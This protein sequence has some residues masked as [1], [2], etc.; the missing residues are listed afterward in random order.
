MSSTYIGVASRN[1]HFL[2][3]K[4][5]VSKTR[6]TR[7]RSRQAIEDHKL[8]HRIENASSIKEKTHGMEPHLF[9]LLPSKAYKSTSKLLLHL[10]NTPLIGSRRSGRGR[11]IRRGIHTRYPAAAPSTSYGR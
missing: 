1:R 6:S 10:T 5:K 7:L 9:N 3:L 8:Q 2:C 11:R 4:I